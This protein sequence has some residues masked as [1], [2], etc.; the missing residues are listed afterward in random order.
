M[1]ACTTWLL[2][3][4]TSTNNRPTATEADAQHGSLSC[5]V[6]ICAQV[7]DSAVNISR[8]VGVPLNVRV[9]EMGLDSSN[10]PITKRQ[11]ELCDKE[12]HGRFAMASKDS[13]AL[14]Q[15]MGMGVNPPPC[16]STPTM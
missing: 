10:M 14:S 11:A 12:W 16:T 5:G 9:E 7:A 6:T 2:Q 3:L 13:T 4:R 15:S 1:H 8:I